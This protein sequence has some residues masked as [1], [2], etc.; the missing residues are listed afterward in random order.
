MSDQRLPVR[1]DTRPLSFQL[2]KK[3]TE[4]ENK[5]SLIHHLLTHYGQCLQ[6]LQCRQD[7]P[8]MRQHS[9]SLAESNSALGMLPVEDSR[10]KQHTALQ[11]SA[12]EVADLV[13]PRTTTGHETGSLL[14]SN[15]V[16]QA[17]TL[18]ETAGSSAS[19]MHGPAPSRP[20][21]TKA[22]LVADEPRP[23][24]SAPTGMIPAQPSTPGHLIASCTAT[25]E[26]YTGPPH[27]TYLPI[28]PFAAMSAA[29]SSSGGSPLTPSAAVAGSMTTP[30]AGTLVRNSP[31]V[32]TALPHLP[33]SRH[34]TGLQQL[35]N[36]V[37]HTPLMVPSP[38]SMTGK[39][40][41]HGRRHS[42][43]ESH[44]PVLISE[45]TIAAEGA[46]QSSSMRGS[47]AS[48]VT[49]GATAHSTGSEATSIGSAH[50]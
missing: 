3:T 47:A 7:P 6:G 44:Q 32:H 28:S 27:D 46:S 19:S 12:N 5:L 26:G 16:Q 42:E 17:S 8:A 36:S 39:Q 43:E 14:S 2:S 18:Y 50:R 25:A 23:Q 15:V 34:S 35:W 41:K 37:A 38:C 20:D 40:S 33:E 4:I 13:Q 29:S 49:D 21:C 48:E 11:E 45:I 31:A 10:G 9:T 22:A 24:G 1:L 30:K